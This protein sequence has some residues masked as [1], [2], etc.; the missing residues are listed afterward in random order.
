M[1]DHSSKNI[2]KSYLL[3]FMKFYLIQIYVNEDNDI[4]ELGYV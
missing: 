1:D 3:I 4:L 2:V